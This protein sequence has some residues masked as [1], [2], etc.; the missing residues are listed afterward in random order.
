MYLKKQ[1]NNKQYFRWDLQDS[2]FKRIPKTSMHGYE[3][4]GIL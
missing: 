4:P 3:Q 1:H 2:G